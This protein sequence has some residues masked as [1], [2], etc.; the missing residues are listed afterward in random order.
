[1]HRG[2]RL[3]YINNQLKRLFELKAGGYGPFL[4][5]KESILKEWQG[6]SIEKKL[7]PEKPKRR[8]KPTTTIRACADT[9][10][11]WDEDLDRREDRLRK[12]YLEERKEDLRKREN[13]YWKELREIEAK[14]RDLD[15]R[16]QNLRSRFIGQPGT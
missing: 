7:P 13:V 12:T 5:Q 11:C 6:E 10:T 3:S 14:K 16:I 15:D 9:L 4:R 2:A 1:M 8:K